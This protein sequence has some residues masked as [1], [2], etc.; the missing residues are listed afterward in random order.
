MKQ[1]RPRITRRRT[2]MPPTIPPIKAPEGPEVRRWGEGDG[3]TDGLV[4]LSPVTGSELE[5]AEDAEE[6][7]TER[8]GED[9]DP[10]EEEEGPVAEA[11]EEE[12]PEVGPLL[13]DVGEGEAAVGEVLVVVGEMVWVVMEVEV[14]TEVDVVVVV[15]DVLEGGGGGGVVSIPSSKLGRE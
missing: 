2:A 6:P 5:G 15:V 12:V 10:C 9:P 8:A 14:A 4:S 1:K 13:G 3:V 11:F 7:W